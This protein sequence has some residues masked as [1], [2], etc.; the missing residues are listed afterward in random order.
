[1]PVNRED[2]KVHV[3][4]LLGNHQIRDPDF[5][6]PAR[7]A[8]HLHSAQFTPVDIHRH[9]SNTFHARGKRQL[10]FMDNRR[11]EF[12]KDDFIDYCLVSRKQIV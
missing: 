5:V 10:V 8:L 1:M 9:T 12:G 6:D 11:Q 2:G 4:R 3:N 7:Q